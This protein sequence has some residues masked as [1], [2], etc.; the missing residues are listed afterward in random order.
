MEEFNDNFRIELENDEL[1]REEMKEK[2]MEEKEMEEK[3]MEE[4]EMEEK[5][6]E[7]ERDEDVE[8]EQREEEEGE[9]PFRVPKPPFSNQQ[10]FSCTCCLSTNDVTAYPFCVCCGVEVS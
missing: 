4:M 6:M 2:K 3:E 9:L 10:G 7:K 8:V 1:Q 5:E